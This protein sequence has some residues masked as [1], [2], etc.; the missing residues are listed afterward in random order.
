M[1]SGNSGFGL[2]VPPYLIGDGINTVTHLNRVGLRRCKELSDG[3]REQIR[4][5]FR[6]L[7]RSDL[8][9]PAALDRLRKEFTSPAVAH[10]VEWFTRPSKRGYCRFKA[11]RREAGG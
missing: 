11:S 5:A 2:D 3:D 8:D 4:R 7:Y 9:L 1:L 10:W 6:V